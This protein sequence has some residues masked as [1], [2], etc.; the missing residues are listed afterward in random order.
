MISSKINILRIVNGHFDSM[1]DGWKILLE[2]KITFF[3][4]PLIISILG[5]ILSFNYS[6]DFYSVLINFSSIL[7]ALL[8]S[9]LVLVCDQE[10]KISDREQSDQSRKEIYKIKIKLFRELYFNIGYSIV[11]S[12]KLIFLCIIYTAI[13]HTN[14]DGDLVG[15][16]AVSINNVM[17]S[18]AIFLTC[19]LLLTLLM[20]VKRMNTML[21]EHNN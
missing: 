3:G 13:F 4:I 20:I 14:K 7:S 11:I 9:V 10:Q 2:D 8:L 21:T 6:K 17:G 19:N 5:Y 15:K 16:Y 12:V 1:R 18:I